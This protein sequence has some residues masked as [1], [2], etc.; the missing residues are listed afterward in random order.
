M[1]EINYVFING[2][3][4]PS[5]KA[6]VLSTD[7]GLQFGWGVFETVQVYNGKACLFSEHFA[8]MRS[9]AEKLGISVNTDEITLM[10]DIEKYIEYLGKGDIVLKIILTKG[11]G[12]SPSIIFTSRE[13]SYTEENY[14]KGFSAKIST[15]KRNPYSPLVYMKTLNYMEN[16]LARQEASGAG[17]DEAIF[18]NTEGLLC[19][20]SVSNIFFVK[21]NLLCTPKISCGILPGVIRNLIIDKLSKELGITIMEGEFELS[22]LLEADEAFLTNSVMEVMPLTRVEDKKIGNGLP[23]PL[24]YEIRKS[25]RVLYVPLHFG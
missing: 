21:D 3:I 15:I 8:R 18:L 10:R 5:E 19:E 1:G 4:M 13:I 6:F 9:S 14:N 20:G 17:Y 7:Q 12:E 22:C 2:E 25:Y 16:I 24:T 11:S 23:G